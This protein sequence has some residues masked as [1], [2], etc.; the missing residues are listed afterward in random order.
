MGNPNKTQP[1][2]ARNRDKPSSKRSAPSGS[3]KGISL[4]QWAAQHR[5]EIARIL[6]KKKS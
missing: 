5:A 2:P 3:S 1:M 4:E 6:E